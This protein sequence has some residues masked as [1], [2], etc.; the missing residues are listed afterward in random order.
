MKILLA[1]ILSILF[2]QFSQAQVMRRPV[3]GPLMGF[4][5][6]S[7]EHTR[8]LSFTANQAALAQLKYASAGV[9]AER[10]FMLNELNDY[11][12][13]IG[14]PLHP[15]A[16]GLKAHYSGSGDYNET[17]LGL[18][19]ARNLG[20]R[21]GV[22]VQFNYNGIRIAGYGSA[23]TVSFETGVVFHITE[24]LHAGFHVNNPVGGRFGKDQQE[25]LPSIY[26]V[27]FGYEASQQFFL[28][29]EITKEEDQPVNVNAGIEYRLIPRLSFSGG[30]TS[31]T[32]SCWIGAGIVF[33]MFE[34]NV[35][36]A[37]HPQLGI[38]P[39]LLLLFNLKEKSS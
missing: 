8:V 14:V 5:A 35:T 26:T 4:G 23:S 7:I 11:T 3:A 21:A 31:S 39:G 10:K 2:H 32:S 33:K 1:L 29:A 13:A 9:Y 24:K 30:V 22:G 18:A 28:G 12:A 17:Q 34:L 25:R 27:G 38:T 20:A 37:Y 19:Y 15:G 16:A 6:Y 36:T